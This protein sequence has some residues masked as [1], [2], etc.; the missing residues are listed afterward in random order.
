MVLLSVY[1]HD[2]VS[3]CAGLLPHAAR[4]VPQHAAQNCLFS[5]NM[6]HLPADL[7]APIAS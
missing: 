5:F 2:T 4:V 3:A 1:G 7:T 6:L